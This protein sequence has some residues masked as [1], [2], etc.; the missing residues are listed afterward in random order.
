MDKV[1]LN[2]KHKIIQVFL[3]SID[4]FINKVINS[5]HFVY[6]KVN[7]GWWDNV[8]RGIS[9]PKVGGFK[10]RKKRQE[11]YS[12]V[13]HNIFKKQYDKW[14]EI[15][16]HYDTQS[17]NLLVGVS[18][19]NGIADYT[20]SLEYSK[21][22]INIIKDWNPGRTYY[23][24]GLFRHYVIL[25]EMKH[26]IEAINV[27]G[28]R[29]HFVGPSYTSVYSK[30][31]RDFNHVC[32]KHKNGAND[33][34]TILNNI[35]RNKSGNDII[36]ASFGDSESLLI[37]FCFDENIS[38]IGIGRAIDYMFKD[39]IN[40]KQVWFTTDHEVLKQNVLKWRKCL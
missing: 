20:R 34:S 18:H 39:E 38:M 36:L 8:L 2:N 31:F 30:L 33:I 11:W 7:H 37:D 29:V 24:G 32:V 10:F 28:T 12:G 26:L 13:K 25:D 40:N 17:E 19:T 22:T 16:K 14:V 35:K 1:W 5:E 4:F 23:H 9:N 15:L 21:T 3:P 27:S 6:V